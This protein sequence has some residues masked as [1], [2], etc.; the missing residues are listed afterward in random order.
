MTE[1]PGGKESFI[2]GAFRA[3]LDDYECWFLA[4]RAKIAYEE[5]IL[6]SGGRVV[7]VAARGRHPV[8]HYADVRR[9]FRTTAFDVVWSHQS[10]LNTLAPTVNAHRRGVPVRIVH[11]HSTRNMG[12]FV[13]GWL[14]PVNQRLL[15]IH[16][17]L[18]F[19][20]SA[21]AGRWF[22]G[23]SSFEVI[24]N[25][26]SLA[27]F[28]HDS[29][30][31][32]AMR[33]E[34]GV[35]PSATVIAHVAR[36]GPEKNHR[37]VIDVVSE[38]SD[39]GV[40]VHALLVGDGELRSATEALARSAGLA[41]RIQFLGRRSDVPDL[42]QAADVAVLPS[43]FEGLPYAILEAQA[44]SLPSVVSDRVSRECDATGTVTFLPLDAPQ[45]EW[46]D[47]IERVTG[48]AY[49]RI[50]GESPL[51]GTRFDSTTLR[52]G[53]ITLFDRA[54]GAGRARQS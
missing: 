18:R 35:P 12:T 48:A 24:P 33:K 38:L 43:L 54:A 16:A 32:T 37:L 13:A 7:H 53:L 3:L 29:A 9:L 21:E 25:A 6:S 19:A 40:D 36:F 26:F 22:Y 4:D 23:S 28:V 14:H 39:R 41:E 1:N 47:V 50:E 46:A 49:H 45:A 52:A 8:R 5:E 44:A 20:C 51:A 34:L 17:N 30:R 10:V 11:S 31:R 42:L 27:P 2:L 15:R